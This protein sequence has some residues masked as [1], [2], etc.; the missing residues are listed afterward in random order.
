[1]AQKEPLDLLLFKGKKHLTKKEIE[2]RRSTEVK[3]PATKINAPSYLDKDLKKEFN[4]IAKQLNEIGIMSNL[5]VDSL[6]RFVQAQHLYQK[7]TDTLMTLHPLDEEFQTLIQHQ[8]KF[9]KQARASAKDLGLTIADRCR[10]VVPKKEEEKK[11]PSKEEKLFG[12]K[13]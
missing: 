3:A 9:Y 4:K 2:E 6:A 12:G 7:I 8:D 5:D 1:M 10:L 13:I 11:E